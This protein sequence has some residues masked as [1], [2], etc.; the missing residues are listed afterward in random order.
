MFFA[1]PR[2]RWNSRLADR[3]RA[4]PATGRGLACMTVAWLAAFTLP[5]SLWGLIL[6]VALFDFG[7]QSV[8]VASQA[9]V[10]RARA[11]AESGLTAAYMVCYSL[12]CGFGAVLATAAFSLGGW[13][14][15]C[16]LGAVI[17]GAAIAFWRITAPQ[18]RP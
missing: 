7:L 10:Y 2:L 4:E 5:W 3:G 8:H 13:T 9:L 18:A 17:S 14:M 6:A 16:S 1:S 15:V 12:G 11:D